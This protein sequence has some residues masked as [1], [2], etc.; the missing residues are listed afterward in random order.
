MERST[1]GGMLRENMEPWKLAMIL[2]LYS[3]IVLKSM[4]KLVLY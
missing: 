2:V 3:A 4:L 1:K